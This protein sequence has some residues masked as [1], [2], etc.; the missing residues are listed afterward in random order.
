MIAMIGVSDCAVE[1]CSR[2]RGDGED[3][4]TGVDGDGPVEEAAVGASA[5]TA[6][7]ALTLPV[8]PRQVTV[9]SS[10]MPRGW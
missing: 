7:V 9:P 6:P 1:V 4:E 5:S 10:L 8:T 3:A 2:S